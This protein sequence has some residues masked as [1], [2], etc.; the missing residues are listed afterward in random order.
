[1]TRTPVYRSRSLI[2]EHGVRWFLSGFEPRRSRPCLLSSLCDQHTFFTK[3]T[4][5]YGSLSFA[6]SGRLTDHIRTAIN[7]MH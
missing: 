1:M 3:Q 2:P 4:A 6:L 7:V 5:G